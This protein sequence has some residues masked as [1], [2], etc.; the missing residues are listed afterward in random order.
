MLSIFE[1]SAYFQT[2]VENF[3]GIFNSMRPS[4]VGAA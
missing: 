1:E 4:A 3:I 2:V